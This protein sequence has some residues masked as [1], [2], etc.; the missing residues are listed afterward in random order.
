MRHVHHVRVLLR[1]RTTNVWCVCALCVFVQN[2]QSSFQRKS[3]DVTVG[4]HVDELEH[5]GKVG[6]HMF[7]TRVGVGA[8]AGACWSPHEY[9]EARSS[10]T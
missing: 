6:L 2:I 7:A 8:G 9:S 4:L 3:V 5:Y 1:E 10:Q